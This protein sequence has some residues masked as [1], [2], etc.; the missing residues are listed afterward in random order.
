MVRTH[1]RLCIHCCTILGFS[2]QDT[3]TL[4]PVKFINCTVQRLLM[5][6]RGSASFLLSAHWVDWGKAG[7]GLSQGWQKMEGEPGEAG[8]LGVT[9]CKH[10]MTFDFF[11]LHFSKNFSDQYWS[12]FHCSLGFQCPYHGR[13]YFGK[14]VK[15]SP[16]SSEPST[17][18][19]SLFLALV[20]ML[21]SPS[22]YALLILLVFVY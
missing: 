18:L 21:S 14:V 12:F 17:G 6:V 5:K 10:I 22:G 8:T 16:E 1:R 9:L 15:S 13:P 19:L 11:A 3:H 7:D 4:T 2:H 20:G